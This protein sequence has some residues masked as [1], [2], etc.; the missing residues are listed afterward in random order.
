MGSYSGLLQF[1]VWRR[2]R[3]GGMRGREGHLWEGEGP[4]RSHTSVTLVSDIAEI[5]QHV[6]V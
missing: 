2:G 3:E 5:V 1:T 4:V 6:L